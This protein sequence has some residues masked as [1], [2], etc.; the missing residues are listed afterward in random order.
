VIDG[1]PGRLEQAKRFG[2]DEVVDMRE[3]DTPER[4]VARIQQLVGG[5]G[6][7]VVVEVTGVPAAAG[8][9]LP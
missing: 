8:A 2:A 3:D 4:R 5:A 6:G 9:R 1:V 7:D